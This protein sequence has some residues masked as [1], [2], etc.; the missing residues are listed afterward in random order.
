MIRRLL[1]AAA[2]VFAPWAAAHAQVEQQSVVDRATLTVQDLMVDARQGNPQGALQNARAVMVCPQVFRAAFIF[3]GSGG[4]CV[5]VA[6]DGAGS[7]SYP[8]FYGIGSGSAGMQAGIQD[9]E[10]LM[11]ILTAKGLGAVMDSQFKFGA[12]AGIAIASIG[13]GVEGATTAGLGADIVVAAKSR[14]LFAGISLQGSVMTTRTSWNRAYYGRDLAARSIVMDMAASNPGADPLREV[15]TRYGG[16]GPV[17]GT[18][19]PP[20]TGTQTAQAP[21]T[22]EPIARAPVQ[23]QSLPPPRR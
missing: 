7:W 23:Q 6:R 16:R 12:D 13:A 17:V 11:I 22:S 15:L 5:L 14:G 2:F 21:I 10:I 9:S 3:G 19:V 20:V 1:A 8:A 18:A 4:D